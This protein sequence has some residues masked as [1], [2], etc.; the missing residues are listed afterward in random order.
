MTSK[1]MSAA[2]VTPDKEKKPTESMAVPRKCGTCRYPVES[3]DIM[4]KTGYPAKKHNKPND[5]EECPGTGKP[6]D[7]IPDV[8]Y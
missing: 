4:G 8:T 6:T 2:D 3:E 5:N 1:K 7:P